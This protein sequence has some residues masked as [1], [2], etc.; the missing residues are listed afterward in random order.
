MDAINTVAVEEKEKKILQKADFK[1]VTFSLAGKDYGID[2]MKVKEIS[3]VDKFTYVPNTYPFVLGVHNLRGDIIS[4]I[5]MRK[6]FNLP[7]EK[8]EKLLNVVIIHVNEYMLGIVVDAI[9]KVISVAR[10]N[11]QLP[12]S[13]LSDIN[14]K[15]LSGVIEYNENLYLILDVDRIFPSDETASYESPSMEKALNKEIVLKTTVKETSVE[16]NFIVETLATFKKFFVTGL[17]R[18]WGEQRFKNWKNQKDS[19]GQDFQLKSETEADDYLASFYSAC[20]GVLWD[21]KLKGALESVLPGSLS[22]P[23]NVWNTG[24]GRGYETYSLGAILRLKYPKDILKL[25][26]NDN[27]L[28]SVSTAP[29]L[30]FKEA[31]VPD[32]IKKNNFMDPCSN[33]VKFKK[34]IKDLIYFEFHD[35]LHTSAMPDIDLVVARDILSFQTPANQ[36]KMLAEFHEK[37]KPGGLLIVGDNEIIDE[38]GWSRIER[39]EMN[40][41]K[42]EQG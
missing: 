10:E 3:K 6:M 9:N 38:T 41:Y 29:N 13:L 24:C 15:Y 12:P 28:L 11:I 34:E 37:L 1:M 42:K 31:D 8:E 39:S 5:D 27:D 30:I 16:F 22:G 32:Y 26:A 7:I 21:A 33:G 35:T 18:L 17:N 40:I 4:L 14:I 25:W 2:I 20:T 36:Q 19:Q 23:M